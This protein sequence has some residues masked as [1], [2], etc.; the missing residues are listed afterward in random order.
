[1]S[2]NLANLVAFPG[3]KKTKE[4]VFVAPAMLDDP[5]AELLNECAELE[6]EEHKEETPVLE[7]S[8]VMEPKLLSKMD[9]ITYMQAQISLSREANRRMDYYVEE[10]EAY[11][12]QK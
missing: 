12:P 9:L 11:L 8:P 7:F 5:L 2:D 1:M 3:T 10:I 4:P 6:S